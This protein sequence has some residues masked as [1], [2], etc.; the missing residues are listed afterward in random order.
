MNPQDSSRQLDA[1][2]WFECPNELGEGIIAHPGRQTVLWFDILGRRLFERSFSGGEPRE[3]DFEVIPSAAALVDDRRILIATEMD[4]RLFDLD[5]GTA[6]PLHPFLDRDAHLR[7]NDGR[8][9]PSGALWISSMGKRAEPRAGAIWWFCRGELKMLFDGITIPNAICFPDAGRIAH[10]SDSDRGIVWRVALDA[11]TGLPA[12]DPMPFRQFGPDEG[13]PDGA[14][15]DADGRV[16]MAA[17]GA[18]AVHAWN[19]DGSLFDTC[20]LPVSQ[21]TSPAFFG[22]V[23]DELLVTTA[24][25]KLSGE[26]L[27]AEPLAG[28]VLKLR[29]K[30]CGV[31]E[32]FV[33]MG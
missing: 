22:P 4:L 24:R 32:P 28:S 19:P 6:Q 30:V 21:P 10:F 15:V 26:V 20:H 8:V 5:A 17:W 14:I 13:S 27:S 31:R 29:R 25:E 7:S 33:R 16:W 9:H 12:G 23:L 1:D 18:S 2:V 3:H 11:D